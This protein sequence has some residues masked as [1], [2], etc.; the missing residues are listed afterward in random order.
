LSG[1]VVFLENFKHNCFNLSLN[2]FET[3]LTILGE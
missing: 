3:D 2:C 1:F